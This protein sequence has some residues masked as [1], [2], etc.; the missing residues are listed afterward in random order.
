MTKPKI[1]ISY[2]HSDI[3]ANWM[4]TFVQTIKNSGIDVWYDQFEV[5]PG[6]AIQEAI[7]KGIRNSNAIVFLLSKNSVFRASSLFELGAAIGMGK[8]IIGIVPDDLDRS[9]LPQP[10]RTRRFVIQKSPE[11]TASEIISATKDIS[12]GGNG[13]KDIAKRA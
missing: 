6:D 12:N 13:E 10:F 7:E 9:L 11:E 1:F 2:A 4:N 8:R 3:D 5:R